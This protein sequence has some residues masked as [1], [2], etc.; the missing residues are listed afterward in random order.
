MYRNTYHFIENPLNGVKSSRLLEVQT[1]F[2][3]VRN[4]VLYV[5][6]DKFEPPLNTVTIVKNNP[7]NGSKISSKLYNINTNTYKELMNNKNQNIIT[8]FNEL[9]SYIL[10]KDEKIIRNYLKKGI[11]Y[12]YN[13]RIIEVII[14]EKELLITFIKDVKF[15]DVKNY[16]FL[17]KGYNGSSLCYSM[18][19]K[20]KISLKYAKKMI[21]NL[22]DIV[23]NSTKDNLTNFLFNETINSV[24]RIDFQIKCKQLNKGTMFYGKRNF[25]IVAKRREGLYIRLLPVKDPKNLLSVVGRTTYE[26][27]CRSY[28][29]KEKK[30]I[31]KI[32]PLIKESYELTKY[33]AIDVKKKFYC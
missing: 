29:I 9:D 12:K 7:K 24:E 31:K 27:L 32:L 21:D 11:T 17:R 25:T 4:G 10:N 1:T 33:P 23:V 19:I 30:D 26:P 2:E 20:D 8:L 5:I 3:L 28:Y 15:Y 16:L 6:N 14:K 22:Y 18:Y 13:K